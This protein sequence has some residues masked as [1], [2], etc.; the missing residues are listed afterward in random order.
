MAD[1]I[2]IAQ[3]EELGQDPVLRRAA[4]PVAGAGQVL[5]RMRAAALNFADLLK[6]QG[7]YQEP[8]D[9][10]FVPGLEGAGE[11]IAA[12]GD[13][14]L[15]P[16]DR[17]AVLAP[18]T[19]AEIV[20]VPAAGCLPIPGAM[21]FAQAAGFQIA[22]GTGHLALDFRA[23]LQ[24]GETLA[25]LGAA[26][27][28]GLTAVEIGHAMGARVIGVARGAQRL[29]RVREAG[30]DEVIDSETC[31]D[32]KSA[33][34]DLGGVDV[35]YDPVGDSA[36]EAAFAALRRGGRFLVIG[37]AG[38]RQ[39]VLPLNHAL[40]KNIAIHGFYWGG[41]HQLDPAALRRS[42]A[43]LF[44]LFEAGRLA[45]VAGHGLPLERI[46]EGYG[47]LRDRKAV[48]KVVISL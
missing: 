20:A 47:L 31:A 39:P 12:P 41:Y 29:A 34:R 25:V 35:V 30:A 9:P 40:V 7:S 18:G 46:A 21:D 14:G 33:L 26:G 24:P 10:P 32:L 4:A 15:T 2:R 38:G 17:V 19:M 5:V 8:S 6:A 13:S 37:F 28:V 16:G 1:L 42:M 11:V 43:R 27:G 45:P 44:A 23:A 22:Y 36:G 3:V 48:G